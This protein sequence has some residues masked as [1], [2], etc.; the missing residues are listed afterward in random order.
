MAPIERSPSLA[1]LSARIGASAALVEPFLSGTPSVGLIVGGDPLEVG[2][3]L[4]VRHHF[5]DG[6]LPCLPDAEGQGELIVGR[7]GAREV[8]VRT[9][10]T[11]REGRARALEALGAVRLMRAL[12]AETLVL[13][14]EAIPLEPMWSAG[15]LALIADHINFSGDNPLVGDNDAAFGPRFPDLTEVYSARLQRLA[16]SVSIE[17]KLRLQRGV[18]ASVGVPNLMTP[19]EYRMLGAFGAD[20]F[21]RGIVPE[22]IVATHCGMEV[23]ALAVL[24]EA[25][26]RTADPERE[27]AAAPDPAGIEFL[28]RVIQRL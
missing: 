26:E 2:T 12:G 8:L 28:E 27:A 14:E 10:P 15:E 23:L 22:S 18:F 16:R 4:E 17:Q 9:A 19:A 1:E 3:R 21:G 20:C 11:P 5:I 24:R 7:F 6:E 13:V 25:R